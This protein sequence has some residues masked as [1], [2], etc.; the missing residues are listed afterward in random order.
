MRCRRSLSLSVGLRCD[1]NIGRPSPTRT[2]WKPVWSVSSGTRNCGNRCFVAL[3]P[4]PLEGRVSCEINVEHAGT[5]GGNYVRFPCGPVALSRGPRELDSIVFQGVC[6]GPIAGGAAESA[7][8][9]CR[10]PAEGSPL[11]RQRR[12][13]VG[14]LVP[15]NV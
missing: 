7:P 10:L 11:S 14:S 13:R 6:F 1:V 8:F 15:P 3:P 9:R 12:C 2:A 4:L 5:N